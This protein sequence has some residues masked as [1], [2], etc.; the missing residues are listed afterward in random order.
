MFRTLS[1]VSIALTVGIRAVILYGNVRRECDQQKYRNK[2]ANPK[3]NSSSRLRDFFRRKVH[4]PAG[5]VSAKHERVCEG[6]KVSRPRGWDSVIAGED[7]EVVY[8]E[9]HSEED[10]IH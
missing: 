2:Y 10:S 5:K 6:R 9:E 4:A 7:G 1:M 8:W 3:E